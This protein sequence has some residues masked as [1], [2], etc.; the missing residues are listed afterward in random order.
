MGWRAEAQK[1]QCD[2]QCQRRPRS[3]AAP[4][5]RLRIGR[6]MARSFIRTAVTWDPMLN[7]FPAEGLGH[8]GLYRDGVHKLCS[9]LSSVN[10]RQP[11]RAKP[12]SPGAAAK[13]MNHGRIGKVRLTLT[14]KGGGASRFGW[15]VGGGA[16]WEGGRERHG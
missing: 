15:G 16:G 8:P 3:H 10:V 1:D 11:R 7:R 5:T 9:L 13:P 12:N 4:E 2:D 14:V 6:H